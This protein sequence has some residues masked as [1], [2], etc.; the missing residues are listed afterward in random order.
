MFGHGVRCL[1]SCPSLSSLLWMCRLLWVLFSH[2]VRNLRD[3]ATP[4]GSRLVWFSI[5]TKVWV[6]FSFPS[7][8]I[9]HDGVTLWVETVFDLILDWNINFSVSLL[10]WSGPSR[11]PPQFVGELAVGFSAR[12]PRWPHFL[13]LYHCPSDE[14][15]LWV[16]CVGRFPLVH[17]RRL[18]LVLSP[19]SFQMG[20]DP[21]SEASLRALSLPARFLVVLAGAAS[22]RKFLALSGVLPY[23]MI[24]LHDHLHCT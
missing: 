8:L 9:L 11:W 3:G 2:M 21:L 16:K 24:R 1:L 19:I 15:T 14:V 12:S 6:C 10:G 20:F 22:L 7:G 4:T 5:G 23:P 18:S 17:D 13:S